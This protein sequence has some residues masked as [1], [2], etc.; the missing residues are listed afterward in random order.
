MRDAVQR[1]A[2]PRLGEPVAGGERTI[3]IGDFSLQ[4]P[5]AE[6]PVADRSGYKQAVPGATCPNIV[7]ETVIGPGVEVVSPPSSDTP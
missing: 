3:R 5:Q 4:R 2:E 7:T 1:H 6:Y